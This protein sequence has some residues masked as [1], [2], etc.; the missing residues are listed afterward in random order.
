MISTEQFIEILGEKGGK[1]IDALGGLLVFFHAF[2]TVTP[3]FDQA[4][5]KLFDW[6]KRTTQRSLENGAGSEIR[7][8]DIIGFEEDRAL[9]P[10][11]P[12]RSQAATRTPEVASPLTLSAYSRVPE[13]WTDGFTLYPPM[14]Q[15]AR[16]FHHDQPAF[17]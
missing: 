13:P 9:K 14:L 11:A 15:P 8:L 4:A 16:H 10:E 12:N 1:G 3:L 17:W 6:F 5:K 7:D 2:V